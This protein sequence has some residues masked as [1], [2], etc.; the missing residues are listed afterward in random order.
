MSVLEEI[1]GKNPSTYAYIQ[2]CMM[3]A[4]MLSLLTLIAA[5]QTQREYQLVWRM[6]DLLNISFL[7][8]IFLLMY[9]YI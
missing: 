2:K 5:Q 7:N 3:V 1:P 4:W 6:S 8:H 9:L